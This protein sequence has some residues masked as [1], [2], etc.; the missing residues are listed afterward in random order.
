M[1]VHLA[2]V[3]GR[4]RQGCGRDGAGCSQHTHA[5]I[6]T[7]IAI[8]DTVAAI[9]SQGTGTIPQHIFAGKRLGQSTIQ[10]V[11]GLQACDR[12]HAHRTCGAVVRARIGHRV[13]RQGARR[14]VGAGL[15]G[16]HGCGGC[17]KQIVG[18]IRKSRRIG[19]GFVR[20]HMSGVK[21]GQTDRPQG[22][23]R[24]RGR[25]IGQQAAHRGCGGAVVHLVV[26]QAKHPRFGIERASTRQIGIVGHDLTA[27]A[28]VI[29]RVE[30]DDQL[31]C[32]HGQTVAPAGNGHSTCRCTGT[33][34]VVVGAQ[35]HISCRDRR[36]SADGH[37]APRHRLQV[38][39]GDGG[40]RVDVDVLCCGKAQLAC[41]RFNG[42]AHRHV[43]PGV[44]R[45]A[46]VGASDGF[47]HI[48]IAGSVQGERGRCC[49]SDGCVDADIAEAR[50][51][52]ARVCG[53]QCDVTA[54]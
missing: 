45:Q 8:A 17:G 7:A 4:D 41:G 1:S 19:D 21:V 23:R 34:A 35:H 18:G 20:A 47:I 32:G 44:Q 16:A 14:D 43:T 12:G 15:V 29:H 42:C 38:A 36:R 53:G 33:C 48:H 5:V 52:G 11:T 39:G 9:G 49:P 37:V 2:H 51:T 50:T 13:D 28:G 40:G 6:A 30:S 26:A 54:P 24:R 25:H 27:G 10:G 3:L 46:A 22:H 31:A